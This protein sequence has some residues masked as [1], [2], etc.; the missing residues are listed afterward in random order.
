M[1]SIDIRPAVSSDIQ[2]IKQF[3][4]S[5]ETSHT[6]QMDNTLDIGQMDV[7]FRKIR[8][9][10]IVKLDY[11]R[12]PATVPDRWKKFDLFLVSRIEARLCGYLTLR[13][14]ED[15]CGRVID[16]V[17]DEPYR[18]QGVASSLLVAAQ[19]WLRN[20]GINQIVLEMQIK[21]QASIALAEKLGYEFSGYMDRYFK[22]REI[23]VFYSLFLR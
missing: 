2:V 19:D 10:R 17:V 6:W 3:S 22:N 15:S 9:P 12:D 11:P 23:A 18:R 13:L 21:N 1:A 20:N 4:H 16:L 8:L 14:E 7:S 5:I